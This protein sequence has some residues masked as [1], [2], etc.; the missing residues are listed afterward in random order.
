M[1]TCKRKGKKL[2]ARRQV[3]KRRIIEETFGNDEV[4]LFP[5]EVWLLIFSF[6]PCKF[7]N[8]VISLVCKNFHALVN[9]PYL[10]NFVHLDISY[11]NIIPGAITGATALNSLIR[12]PKYIN[13]REL[14]IGKTSIADKTLKIIVEKCPKLE[15]L[16]IMEGVDITEDKIAQLKDSLI[17]ELCIGSFKYKKYTQNIFDGF[18][19]LKKLVIANINTCTTYIL[20]S[21]VQNCKNLTTLSLYNPFDDSSLVLLK[22]MKTL[23]SLM[24]NLAW[25]AKEECLIKSC[26]K[27]KNL[28]HLEIFDCPFISDKFIAQLTKYCK[29]LKV[30]ELF[31][32]NIGGSSSQRHDWLQ[33]V[34]RQPN[35][36][37]TRQS[38]AD[39]HSYGIKAV[40]IPIC[41]GPSQFG[42]VIDYNHRL[43]TIIQLYYVFAK[44]L[45]FSDNMFTVDQHCKLL[46]AP[47][48]L[49]FS[50]AMKYKNSGNY[51]KLLEIL[52]LAQRYEESLF[53]Y[54][55]SI[56]SYMER[57][58]RKV[59]DL[60]FVLE[61][62]KLFYMYR[63]RSKLEY[64]NTIEFIERVLMLWFLGQTEPTRG[65]QW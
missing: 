63:N 23:K 40:N 14:Y 5:Q 29:N 44:A 48:S 62:R 21:I 55:C 41:N 39:L 2:V 65:E 30:L 6:L 12:K 56:E 24:I 57:L 35:G 26:K 50:D 17:T 45:G 37:L 19:N 52:F 28:I 20:G 47:S 4:I 9:S 64:E 46:V 31:S 49:S 3:K 10:W 58:H 53:Q 22:K 38:Y 25:D 27:L 15:K 34:I 51:I 13:L 8:W 59:S 42:L 43:E 7:L 36:P 60:H 11:R 18:P 1:E 16:A 32:K 33:P 54:N 61:K